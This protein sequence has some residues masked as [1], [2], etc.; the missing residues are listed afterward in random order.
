MTG[1]EEIRRT[2]EDTIGREGCSISCADA[3]IFEDAEGWKFQL[4]TFMGPWKLGKTVDEA[5]RTITDLA[6]QGFGLS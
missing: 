2:L 3:D 6:S 5:K 1:S 4:P